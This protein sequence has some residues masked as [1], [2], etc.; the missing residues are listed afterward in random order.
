MIRAVVSSPVFVPVTDQFNVPLVIVAPFIEVAVATPRIG[1]TRVGEVV[2][3]TFPVP[4]VA[5]SP[6]TQALSYSMRP[7][8]PLEIP[9]LHIVIPLPQEAFKVCPVI[10]RFVPRVISSIVPVPDVFL[11]KSLLVVI[12]SLFFVV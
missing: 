8:T 12:L 6:T 4:F 11:P 3:D 1:V 10:D 9:V 5:S 2:N 7:D